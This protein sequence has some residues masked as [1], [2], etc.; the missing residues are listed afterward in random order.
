[1]PD[2]MRRAPLVASARPRDPLIAA[3]QTIQYTQGGAAGRSLFQYHSWQEEAWANWENLGEAN[4]AVSWMASALSRVRLLA[5]EM[6]PGG[7]EPEPITEGPAAMAM[8]RLGGG[9]GG[10]SGLMK[11]FAPHV[12]VPGE[13]W[14]TGEA[15]SDTTELWK[16][17]S[18]DE[19]RP[20]LTVGAKYEVREDERVWRPLPPNTLVTRV[21]DPHPR[22]SYEATSAF[23]A[24]LPIMRR[25]DLIDRR[26]V[27]TMVSRIAMN[28]FLLIPTEGN[29]P[30]ADKYKD[31]PDPFIAMIIDIASNNIKNPGSA[32]AALPMPIKFAGPWI[33]K[34]RH[35][36]VGDTVTTELLEERDKELRRLATTLNVPA[37]VVLGM[38]D[39]SHWNA[40]QIEDSA[41]KLH[42]SP[43][44]ELICQCLT[45]GM[46]QPML[47]AEGADLIGPNGGQIVVWYDTSEL[48]VAPDKTEAVFRAYDR[49]EATGVALRREIGLTEGDKPEGDELREQILKGLAANPQ[50][51]FTA[52]AELLGIQIPAGGPA[53]PSPASPPPGEA[54]SPPGEPAPE[55][56]AGT[57]HGPP[58][59]QGNP[60]PPP[61]QEAKQ[62]GHVFRNPVV[63]RARRVERDERIPA[64]AGQGMRDPPGQ[65][66]GHKVNGHKT[67]RRR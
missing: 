48:T 50:A 18:A 30:T 33:E 53:Y 55:P 13:S 45:I 60:P 64:M 19:I 35:L 3:A 23:K 16:V 42:V 37:E 41:I 34:W 67:G 6:L 49:L 11:A 61:G 14:L 47:L 56:P 65:T 59:T 21:W 26:I 27:A 44:A 15:T 17:R 24:A 46:L 28:G 9:I 58:G 62:G 5:A 4:W 51:G 25:I 7:D 20:A 32:T 22:L 66:N 63:D 31:A 57:P 2:R 54:E 12:L 40:W 38:G 1:M 29:L 39:T 52:L 8:Q 10:Q 36:T 43:V